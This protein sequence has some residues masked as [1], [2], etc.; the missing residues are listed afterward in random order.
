MYVIFYIKE[1]NFCYKKNK[2]NLH[3]SQTRKQIYSHGRES[4][5]SN[6]IRNVLGVQS[7]IMEIRGVN[8]SMLITCN[9]WKV[10]AP[11]RFTISTR[12]AHLRGRAWV[13]MDADLFHK[14]ASKL[15][16]SLFDT[17][18]KYT[19]HERLGQSES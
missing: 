11:R 14:P 19:I 16:P 15:I 1:N 5:T 13:I 7:R 10:T 3:R 4:W 17:S 12:D 9:C 18:I 6:T 8:K 2:S